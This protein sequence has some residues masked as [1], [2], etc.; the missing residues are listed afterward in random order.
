MALTFKQYSI[1]EDHIVTLGPLAGPFDPAMGM[2]MEGNDWHDELNDQFADAFEFP[3]LS[4]DIGY[5][6]VQEILAGANLAFP[7]LTHPADPQD[8]EYIYVIPTNPPWFLYTA[9]VQDEQGR[10]EFYAEIMDENTINDF[11]S[12]NLDDE[13]EPIET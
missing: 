10:C 5:R 3:I 13:D 9:Y 1:D 2:T 6:R 11:L 4:P 7:V 12:A 8:G